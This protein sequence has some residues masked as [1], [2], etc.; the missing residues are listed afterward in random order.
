MRR[1]ALG[2][3][4]CS[5]WSATSA[6]AQSPLCE[7]RFWAS[8]TQRSVEIMLQR[9]DDPAAPCPNSREGD[10]PLHLAAASANDAGAVR[11]LAAAGGDMTLRNAA[12]ATPFELFMRRYEAHVGG[13][14]GD[15]TLAALE[16]VFLSGADPATSRQW[17]TA[18]DR[19][20]ESKS[21]GASLNRSGGGGEPGAD[22]FAALDQAFAAE[23]GAEDAAEEEAAAGL[24]HAEPDDA[25]VEDPFAALDRAFAAEVAGDAAEAFA[26]EV[27]A[28]DAE[29]EAAAG[30]AHAEPDDVPVED[31][32]AALD[33]A[34][35]AAVAGDVADAAADPVAADGV[36]AAALAAPVDAETSVNAA[37][38]E[39]TE[40]ATFGA[41]VR[42]V[43][44][45]V[46]AAEDAAAAAQA[47]AAGA[48]SWF[49]RTAAC[50]GARDRL[51]RALARVEALT[52]GGSRPSF[53]TS[54]MGEEAYAELG[55][56]LAS[57]RAQSRACDSI[58]Q[59]R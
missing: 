6:A 16:T 38:A 56:R 5:L 21:S 2:F 17:R 34:F 51:T 58:E 24:A 47:S 28:E 9:G 22:P 4:L 37:D 52:V 42:A 20:L 45:S 12:G 25:P 57:A 50:V 27:G 3:L 19:A 18:L 49:A 41:W 10:T 1:T 44:G 29:E 30:L 36:G 54:A 43:N 33:R 11:A 31:P 40:P 32:F 39:A 13:G 15:P 46:T 55:E 14:A 8:T 53:V 35:A 23:V 48:G 7:P 59:Q 26:A